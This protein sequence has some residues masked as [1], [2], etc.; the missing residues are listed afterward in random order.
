MGFASFKDAGASETQMKAHL[1]DGEMTSIT[2]RIPMN[3]KEAG[4][5]RAGL[6]SQSLSAFVRRSMVDELIWAKNE[7]Q[8]PE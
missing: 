8:R 5:E 2:V 7:H 4:A 6:E 3:L 1:N